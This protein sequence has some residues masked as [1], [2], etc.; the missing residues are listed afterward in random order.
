MNWLRLE[1]GRWVGWKLGQFG[2]EQQLDI[3]IKVKVEK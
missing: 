2:P 3:S 1:I